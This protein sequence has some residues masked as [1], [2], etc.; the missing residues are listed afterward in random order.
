[1]VEQTLQLKTAGAGV[2]ACFLEM[3]QNAKS[4]ASIIYETLN[5]ALDRTS[6]NLAKLLTE[7]KPKGGWGRR[8]GRSSRTSASL[9]LQSSI[10]STLQSGLGAIGQHFGIRGA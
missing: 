7:K 4:A 5:S 8:S 9:Q 1:M 6:E 10:K 2:K 3:Q